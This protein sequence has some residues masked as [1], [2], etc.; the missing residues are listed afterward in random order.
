MDQEYTP[1]AESIIESIVKL[2]AHQYGCTVEELVI[3]KKDKE[4]APV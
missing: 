4:E 3:K 2:L 1:T